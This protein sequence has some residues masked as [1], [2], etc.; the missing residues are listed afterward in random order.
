MDATA[1]SS[2]PARSGSNEL[3][4][5]QRRLIEGLRRAAIPFELEHPHYYSADVVMVISTVDWAV[6]P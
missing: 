5:P 1:V 6:R 3:T 2:I 4:L